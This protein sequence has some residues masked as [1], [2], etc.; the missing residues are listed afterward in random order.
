MSKKLQVFVS[1]AYDDM[2]VERQAVIEAIL[3]AGH[4]PAGMGLFAAG[5]KSQL[6]IIKR[7][8]QDSDVYMLILGGR[9]GTIERILDENYVQSEY[10]FA[11]NTETILC[12]CYARRFPRQKVKV[13]MAGM[14]WSRTI[15]TYSNGSEGRSHPK[16]AVFSEVRRN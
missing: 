8:I 11:E 14:S 5:D 9:Y 16:Y 7:W 12:R 13:H 10:E 2:K 4:I 3:R 15:P 6:E 1:S